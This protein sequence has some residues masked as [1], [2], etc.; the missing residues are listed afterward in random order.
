MYA[1]FLKYSEI[2]LHKKN[3]VFHQG[4]FSKC[5]QMRSNVNNGNNQDIIQPIQLVTAT[6]LLTN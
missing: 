6:D 4:F 5:D 3:I 2:Q 1:L